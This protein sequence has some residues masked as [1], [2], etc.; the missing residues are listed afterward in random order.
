MYIFVLFH[1]LPFSAV[2]GIVTFT[3]TN[4]TSQK[5]GAPINRQN[6]LKKRRDIY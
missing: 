4:I 6:I 2:V 3:N 5:G 1:K